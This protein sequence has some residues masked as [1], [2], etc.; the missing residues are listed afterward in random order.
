MTIPI[1]LEL[2][3]GLGVGP[4]NVYLFPEPEPVL[5]DTGIRSDES[6]IALTDGLAQ[7]G[8]T[9]ADISRVVITHPHVDHFGQAGRIANESGAEIWI[10]DVGRPWLQSTAEMWQQRI[11]YY[12]HHFL[13]PVGLPPDAIEV[14][15]N[16]M[17]GIAA[18][19][20]DI[21]PQKIVTFKLDGALHMGG[22]SWQVLH[23]PGHASAQTCFYQ[24]ETRRLLSADH[25]LAVAPTP[26]VERPS[27]GVN[28]VPALP[29]F[30]QSLDLVQQLDID[31]VYPGHGRPFADHRAVIR[32][33]R[34]RIQARKRQ[35]MELICEGYRTIAD[36]LDVMYA[37][38]P[39]QFRFAGL[40]MLV[41]Y[42]DLLQAEGAIEERT[43]DGVWHYFPSAPPL[44]AALP[45]SKREK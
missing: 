11:D 6:W 42:L 4:V 39:P 38:H 14:I 1:R 37:H 44:S 43:I 31:T 40:W 22:R 30:L 15:I 5:V 41:G 16:G 35:A 29:Q 32:H 9:V 23:T 25:L 20:Y 34:D 2:P 24:V 36:M 10:A 27:D 26:V 33:Q 17:R 13:Q 45:R 18:R 19:T 3:T 8:L 21:P 12:R 28:R 7:H